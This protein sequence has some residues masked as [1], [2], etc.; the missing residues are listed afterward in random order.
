MVYDPAV[1]KYDYMGVGQCEPAKHTCHIITVVWLLVF[2]LGRPV[3]SYCTAVNF[4]VVSGHRFNVTI[5]FWA[6]IAVFWGAGVGEVFICDVNLY[7][8]NNVHLYTCG[9]HLF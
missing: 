8:P 5:Y 1:I 9:I 3:R 7:N 2:G 6:F 4:V